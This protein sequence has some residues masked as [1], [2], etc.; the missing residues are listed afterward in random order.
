MTTVNQ[1][2]WVDLK[3]ERTAFPLMAQEEGETTKRPRVLIVRGS[4]GALGGAERELLQLVCAVDR[5]W[6]VTLATLDLS[7]IHI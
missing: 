2:S 7:L 4:F 3:G 6:E 1:Q 5:R